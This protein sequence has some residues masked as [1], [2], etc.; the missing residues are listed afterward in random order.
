MSR[1]RPRLASIVVLGA[2]LA[3]GWWLAGGRA[4]P[5]R[6]DGKDRS[7]RSQSVTGPI[8]VET[9]F[10]MQVGAGKIQAP[11]D[12]VY[13]IDYGR[14]NLYAA[15]PTAR[16][17]ANDVSLL[18]DFAERDLAADF[19]L[20][21]GVEPRFLMSTASLGAMAQGTSVLLVIETTT[22]QIAAYQASVKVNSLDGRPQ[23]DRLQLTSYGAARR[24]EADP[25]RPRGEPVVVRGPLVIGQSTDGTQAPLD[26][27]FWLDED[28]EPR[29]HAAIPSSRKTAGET[30]VL[31]GIGERDLAADFR[32]KPG[33]SPRFLLNS[34]SLGAAVQGA[35][36][37]MVI[38]TTTKQ[39]AAYRAAPRAS[40]GAGAKAEVELVQ[41]KPYVEAAPLP[42][43]PAGE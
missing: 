24:P 30:Q 15:I 17:A 16:K 26:V 7:E 39:V 1:I 40:A 38:E 11:L 5:L 35:S 3:G 33:A 13:W 32:L 23:F 18:R 31:G 36:A 43:L 41:V 19:A 6:A 29:L 22:R 9:G 21:P 10:A 28:C 14:A 25:T 12:A 37:L 2:G 4:A 42:P 27:V 20:A 34:V 8:K